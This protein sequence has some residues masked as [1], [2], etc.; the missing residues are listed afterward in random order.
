MNRCPSCD[1]LG[2]HQHWCAGHPG[3]RTRTSEKVHRG[4]ARACTVDNCTEEHYPIPHVHNHGTEDGLG[5]A[6]TEV[7]I[8]VCQLDEL[9]AAAEALKNVEDLCARA[10]RCI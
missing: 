6:C 9:M 4:L 7:L 2:G 10:G 5:L 3:W 1:T 8:G